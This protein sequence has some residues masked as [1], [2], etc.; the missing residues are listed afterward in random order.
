MLTFVYDIQLR[1]FLA[2]ILC[3]AI[4]IFHMFVY[5]FQRKSDNVLESFSLGTHVVLC[6][7]TLI[8]ALYYGEDSSFSKSLYVLNVIEKILIVAPV[9]IFMIVAIFCTAIKLIFCLRLCLAVLIP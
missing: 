9:S 8:K 3:V 4:L 6:G 5:P 7:L 2:L 1:L